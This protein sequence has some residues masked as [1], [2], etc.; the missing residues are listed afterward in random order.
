MKRSI[1]LSFTLLMVMFA[2]SVNAKESTKKNALASV[3]EKVEVYYFH[4]TARCVT[5]KT[6]EAEAKADVQALY[7]GKVSFQAINLDDASSK[8]IAEKLKVPGQ[9]LLIVKGK[10]I[11]NITN[12]GFMYARK[13]P[14]KFKSVIKE[15]VDAF[16]K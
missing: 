2:F 10:Q 9:A 8:E 3:P 13:D 12:E 7:G 5:C 11:V 6:V 1:I 14:A 15:K 4:M 16:L